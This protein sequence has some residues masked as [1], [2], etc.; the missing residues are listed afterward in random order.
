MLRKIGLATVGLV[1]LIAIL[2]A[3]VGVRHVVYWSPTEEV[4][5]RSGDIE[6]AG[7]LVKPGETGP[8]PTVVLLHGSGPQPR[9]EPPTRAI[10]NVLVRNGFSVLLYDK[11][12]VGESSGDFAAALYAD[13][14]ADATA[15]VEYLATRSDID[16]RAIGL[17]TVS[18]GAWFGPE[19]AVR[20][21]QIAFIFNQV[22]SPLAVEECWLWEIGNEYV[23]DGLSHTD[24]NTL[25]SLARLRWDYYQDTAVD[26]KLASGPR[27]DSINAEIARLYSEIPNAER[28]IDPQLAAYDATENKAFAANSSYDPGPF[29]EQLKIPLY[30]AFGEYDVN[31]PTVQ[32]AAAL[33]SLISEGKDITYKVFP[34]VGHNLATWKG[35]LDFG[36]VPGYLDA[37]DEWTANKLP[38]D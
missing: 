38:K 32:S 37:L 24:A 26:A 1:G 9:S 35:A 7:T 8:F 12:G 20:T 27:R 28:Y 25:V 22:G 11:R 2:I 36:Y 17:Y 14:V 10:V 31:V 29:I 15:A 4:R 19:V 30:Y 6:L 5:F 23:Q 33:E 34:G 18:E 3:Y 13:F 16:Q 21:G